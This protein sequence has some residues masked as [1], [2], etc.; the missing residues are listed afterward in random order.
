[1]IVAAGAMGEIAMDADVMGEIAIEMV[2]IVTC[3]RAAT[4]ATA[5]PEA[6]D[7]MV[8][9]GGVVDAT[10]I[11]MSLDTRVRAILTEPRTVSGLRA[12]TGWLHS[13]PVVVIAAIAVSVVMV[14][15]A[16]AVNVVRRL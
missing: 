8:V 10:E 16:S 1:V 2:G 7:V 13:L 11:K 12:K 15:G 9:A 5:I 4:G 3:G 6:R 14:S